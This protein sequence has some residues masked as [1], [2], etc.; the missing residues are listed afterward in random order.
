MTNQHDLYNLNDAADM[1]HMSKDTLRKK[2]RPHG[3]WP[4]RRI[5]RRILFTEDDISTIIE[6]SAT[7]PE[8]TPQ[9]NRRAS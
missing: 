2:L 5:G 8:P 4:A 7:R 3:D 1:L 6:M 9:R